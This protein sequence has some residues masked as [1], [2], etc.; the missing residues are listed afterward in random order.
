MIFFSKFG[1]ALRHQLSYD[2]KS[3]PGNL[4]L[5]S[6]HDGTTLVADPLKNGDDAFLEILASRTARAAIYLHISIGSDDDIIFVLAATLMAKA[7][8]DYSFK[9]YAGRLITFTR[10]EVEKNKGDVVFVTMR[11][12]DQTGVITLREISEL[13]IVAKSLLK[14]LRYSNQEIGEKVK[15]VMDKS[16]DQRNNAGFEKT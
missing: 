14:N 5:W 12:K 11:H 1:Y 3:K 13:E 7:G 15:A 6:S 16:L 10:K 4:L 9:N 8:Q 2:P